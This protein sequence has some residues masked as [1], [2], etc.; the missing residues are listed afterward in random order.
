MIT[1]NNLHF[2]GCYLPQLFNC[3]GH[4]L[5]NGNVGLAVTTVYVYLGSAVGGALDVV[6]LEQVVP[7]PQ[8]DLIQIYGGG[9][10]NQIVDGAAV[11][12]DCNVSVVVL[13]PCLF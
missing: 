1:R 13:E 8:D 6:C 3:F 5:T 12:L 9:G 7:Y 11:G 10:L 4:H 2:N